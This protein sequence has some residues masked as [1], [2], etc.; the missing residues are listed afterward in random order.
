MK[1]NIAFDAHCHIF[2]LEYA[3]KEARHMLHD[4][5]S[6]SY[7]K[8]IPEDRAIKLQ[9]KAKV[10]KN[11]VIQLLIQFYEL[12]SASLGSEEENL[13]FLL[14]KASGAMSDHEWI[15]VPLMMDI[16]YMYAYP[17]HKGKEVTYMERK[18]L[19]IPDEAELQKDWNEILDDLKKYIESKKPDDALKKGTGLDH[20]LEAIEAERDVGATITFKAGLESAKGIFERKGQTEGYYYHLINLEKLVE[21]RKGELYPFIAVDPRR[22]G[23]IDEIVGGKYIG[24]DGPFYGVK[25]YPRLGYHPECEPLDALYQ[26]CNDQKIPI[27]FHCGEGGFPPFK[28]WEHADFGHPENFRPILDKYPDL[29][30]NFAHLGSPIQDC[31]WSGEI[32]GLM[33]D[34][35]TVYSDLSCY[36][37]ID[38]LKA[39]KKLWDDN[40]VLQSRL[41]FGTD[42]DVMYFMGEINLD[43]YF[44][45]FKSTFSESELTLLIHDNPTK[46]FGVVL[47]PS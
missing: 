12:I 13:D 30:I 6:G 2:T 14:K 23:I 25:L 37:D 3:L 20:F 26:Y 46:F 43:V 7:P 21:K 31:D 9:T 15:V 11:P 39:A 32:I 27:T 36:V 29:K 22:P 33:E 38:N 18:M 47:A 5:L 42:F 41:M 1:K 19:E 34:F 16:Y 8:D 44:D 4:M 17:V 10:I 40:S 24:N 35:E 28:N 45:N